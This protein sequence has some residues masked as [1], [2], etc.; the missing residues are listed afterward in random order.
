MPRTIGKINAQYKQVKISVGVGS[1]AELE[2]GI[3]SAQYDV[4]IATLP[5]DQQGIEVETLCAVDCVAIVPAGHPLSSRKTIAAQDL[6]H[7]RQAADQP[8]R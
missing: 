2:D 7:V 3:A 1:R 4:G 5:V 6:R 8:I